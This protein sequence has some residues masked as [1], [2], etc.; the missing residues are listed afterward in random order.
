MAS[1]PHNPGL[2]PGRYVGAE[3]VVDDGE[4]FEEKMGRLAAKLHIQI[5]DSHKLDTIIESNLKEFGY[6]E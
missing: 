5:A 2:T 4:P 1:F 6:S 3:D